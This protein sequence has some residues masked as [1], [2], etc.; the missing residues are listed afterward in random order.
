MLSFSQQPRIEV[1]SLWMQ[2]ASGSL[3][4]Q[5]IPKADSRKQLLPMAS[6]V[7]FLST[8]TTAERTNVTKAIRSIKILGII[9][10]RLQKLF[11]NELWNIYPQFPVYEP[12]G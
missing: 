8:A 12:S 9:F 3:G 7:F 6:F 10:G 4:P 1:M 11:P 5:F 2:I